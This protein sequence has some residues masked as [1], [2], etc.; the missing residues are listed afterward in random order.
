MFS[1]TCKS[2]KSANH[3]TKKNR[4]ANQTNFVKSENLRIC[5]LR[6]C[7]LRNLFAD[8]HPLLSGKGRKKPAAPPSLRLTGKDKFICLQH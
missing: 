1:Q 4:C 3:I 5:D 2:F 7:D 8:C 6:I